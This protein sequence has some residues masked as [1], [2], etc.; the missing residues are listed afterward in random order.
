MTATS[1]AATTQRLTSSPPLLEARGVAKRF[2]AQRDVLGRPTLWRLAVDDVSLVIARGETLGLVGESG[3]GK[4]TLGRL[5]IGLLAPSSGSVC[6][7]GLELNSASAEEL[8]RFRQRAQIVFQDPYSSLDPR[9][10][11]G[12]IVAEGMHHLELTRAEREER[13]AQLLELVQ[14]PRQ[15][16]R[17]YP[18]EFSG[19]QR[20]RISIARA[21]A[22]GPEFL[23]ADEPV[24][25]LDVSV[26]S[27]VL[28]LLADLRVKL[29]LTL[30]FIS[31]DTSVIQHLAD[32]VAVMYLGRVVEAGPTAAVLDSPRHPYTQALLSSAPRLVRSARLTK[33]IVLQ[34]DIPTALEPNLPQGCRFAGRCFRRV[35][36]CLSETPPL[37]EVEAGHHVACF[38][39]APPEEVFGGHCS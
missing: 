27:N 15:A 22:V 5:L 33:R 19:G 10:Q 35:E 37:E 16:M 8:R 39:P 30:L 31:H 12:R 14:L 21:L 38:N 28:N 26:Q 13:V 24:S 1:S 11:V 7:D 36:R 23:V 2:P 3:C 32:R 25:A 29:G 34:G 20:Q 18:H 17:R 6:F 4:S 9:M